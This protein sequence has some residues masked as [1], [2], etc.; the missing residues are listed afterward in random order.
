M[1]LLFAWR[2]VRVWFFVLLPFVL[3]LWVSTIYLRHH[4]VV[5][6]FAGWALVPVALFLAP[7]LD[8]YWARKQAEAGY[9]PPLGA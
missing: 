8:R 2:F 4:Y 1:A 3:G 7:R 5:D 6:L 9:S